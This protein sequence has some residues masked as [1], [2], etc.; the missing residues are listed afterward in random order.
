MDNVRKNKHLFGNKLDD[1]QLASVS[2]FSPSITSSSSESDAPHS[3]ATVSSLLVDISN[4]EP[5][6]VSYDMTFVELDPSSYPEKVPAADKDSS[7]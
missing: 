4:S 3:A 1:I 6:P 2:P 7:R 5:V